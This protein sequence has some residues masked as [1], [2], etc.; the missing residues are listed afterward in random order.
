MTNYPMFKITEDVMEE[1]N[2]GGATFVS[3]GEVMIRDTPADLERPERTRLVRLSM[4]G[5]EFTL[6]VGLSRL[7]I[8]S[9]YI[10]RIPDNAY[11]HAVRNATREQGA[12]ADHIVWAS[13]TEPIGRLI[14]EIGRTPRKNI[15]VYQRMYS[16]ASRLGQGM[17]DWAEA[18]K[19][20]RLFHTSGITLGL[21]NHS[22]YERNYCYEAY[23]EAIDRKP[24]NCSVGLDFNYRSTLWSKEE[25]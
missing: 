25:A 9:S 14:Y 16:A 20:T 12:I 18:L 19:G 2:P 3:F 7:G 22:G 23:L 8:H 10:T 1:H 4:A 17:V 24:E 13:K 6:A 21:A 11:G 15:A 5:S